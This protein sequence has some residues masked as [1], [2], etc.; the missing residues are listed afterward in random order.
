MANKDPVPLYSVLS[1]HILSAF[2]IAQHKKGNCSFKAILHQY[3]TS[4]CGVNICNFRKLKPYIYN[5]VLLIT[6][7]VS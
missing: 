1:L 2:Q 5:H 4:K 6:S 7:S 3:S